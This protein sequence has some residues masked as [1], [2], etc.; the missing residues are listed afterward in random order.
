[1]QTKK[2][3]YVKIIGIVLLIAIAITMPIK[4]LKESNRIQIHGN[5]MFPTI[6]DGEYVTIEYNNTFTYGDIV[7]FKCNNEFYCKRIIGLPNDVIE[8]KEDAILVN[9]ILKEKEGGSKNDSITY[10]IELQSDEYFVMGDNRA[11][12]IDSRD[13]RIGPILKD[14]I[15]GKVITPDSQ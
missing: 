10:P 6:T 14:M 15:I 12:S 13:K 7:I 8:I 9:G 4:L 11:Y 3:S 5:S 1:M 2:I